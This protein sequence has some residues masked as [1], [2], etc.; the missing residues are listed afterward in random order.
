MSSEGA[1]AYMSNT[2]SNC[3]W[4]QKFMQDIHRCMEDVW[5]PNQAISQYELSLCINVLEAIRG[6]AQKTVIN[7]YDMKC[8]ATT[9]CI[10]LAGYFASLWG[11]EINYMDLEAMIKC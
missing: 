2:V 4:F 1:S 3:V 7:R 11:E 10:V 8:T 6:E 9:A 5:L